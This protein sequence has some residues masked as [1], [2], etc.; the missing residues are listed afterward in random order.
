MPRPARAQH[1]LPQ[2]LQADAHLRRLLAWRCQNEQLQRIYG[3]AW[4]D[5]KQLDAY[6]LRMEEADKRDHRKI[7]KA[8]DLFHLQEEVPGLVFWHPKGWS[9][10]QVVEQ[11]MRK[12][13]RDSGYGGCVARRSWTCRCG[14]NPATGTTTRTRC[15]SPNRRSAPTQSSR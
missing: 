6:I 13:Y 9:L 2:G 8:Q 3:T 4:A 14:R 7:G 1:A 10:W 5:K 12:V 11:Y 15:S